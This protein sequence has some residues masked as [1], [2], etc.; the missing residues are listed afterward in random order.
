MIS[1][2]RIVRPKV[3]INQICHHTIV[4]L[5]TP[6]ND[7]P[8]AGSPAC[9]S[10][11]HSCNCTRSSSEIES[12]IPIDDKVSKH[13]PSHRLVFFLQ[14]VY[15]GCYALSVVPEP[16][17]DRQWSECFLVPMQNSRA[18]TKLHRRWRSWKER[19]FCCL[20]VGSLLL[21]LLLGRPITCVFA[22]A[23]HTDAY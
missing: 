10:H 18:S 21:L 12:I 22:C 14:H 11:S 3:H 17:A 5:L 6:T 20:I 16:V 19:S 4:L 13:I 7:I 2:R 23:I 15:D 9:K 8:H 1:S